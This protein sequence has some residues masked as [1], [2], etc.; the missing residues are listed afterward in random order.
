M[1]GKGSKKIGSY[2]I[3]S[4]LL[5]RG[6]FSSV[7]LAHRPDRSPLAVKVIAFEVVESNPSPSQTL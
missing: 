4:Q 6:S 5:G 1:E 2:T 3:S 7:Y